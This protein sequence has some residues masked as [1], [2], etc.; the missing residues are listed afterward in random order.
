MGIR[1][2]AVDTLYMY[3]PSL[4]RY[5]PRYIRSHVRSALLVLRGTCLGTPLCYIGM[6][7]SVLDHIPGCVVGSLWQ[8]LGYIGWLGG[9]DG[10]R[11]LRV[12]CR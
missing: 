3:L 1:G 4:G 7:I 5:I 6:S 9:A 2:L 11:M 10:V 8:R 12:P